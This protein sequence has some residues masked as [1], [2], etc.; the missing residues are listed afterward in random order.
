MD[1]PGTSNEL[2]FYFERILL[3]WGLKM[4][5]DSNP[6]LNCPFEVYHHQCEP[7]YCHDDLSP[8]QN[9]VATLPIVPQKNLQL[10]FQH[11]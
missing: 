9:L 4:I 1:H 2:L 10:D 8:G 7:S 3:Q 6:L 5:S 11:Q